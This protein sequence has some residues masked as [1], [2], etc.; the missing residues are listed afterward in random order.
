MAVGDELW[1]MVPGAINVHVIGSLRSATEVL[2]NDDCLFL[3]LSGGIAIAHGLEFESLILAIFIAVHHNAG[4]CDELGAVNKM[5]GRSF[6]SWV[7]RS[8]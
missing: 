8:V 5:D 6:G 3:A 7:C 4:G 2:E 1:I